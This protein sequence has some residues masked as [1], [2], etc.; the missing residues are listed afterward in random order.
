MKLK[1]LPPTLR[2]KK[3]YLVVEI[4]SEKAIS[5]DEL[6]SLVWSACI[7]FHGESKTSDFRLWL[8]NLFSDKNIHLDSDSSDKE[9]KKNYN[10]KAILRCQRGY[11]KDIR[12]ALCLLNNY[13]GARISI[14]TIAK[15][16]T[17]NSAK[18]FL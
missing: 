2:I 12:S 9:N 15:A 5:K 8:I 1:I 17:I 13:N 6:V 4:K 14:N 3:R 7:S 10:Y 18:K 16:G 11:E